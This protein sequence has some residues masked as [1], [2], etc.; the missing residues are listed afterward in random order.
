MVQESR[1][2]IGRTMAAMD[3]G[4]EAAVRDVLRDCRARQHHSPAE[5][6]SLAAWHLTT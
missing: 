6:L 4:D 2:V 3:A 1:V 5:C